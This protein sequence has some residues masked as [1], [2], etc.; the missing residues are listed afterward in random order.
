M[1][2]LFSC[3]AEGSQIIAKTGKSNLEKFIN[4]LLERVERGRKSYEH[5]GNSINYINANGRT[6]L[7]IAEKGTNGRIVFAYLEKIQ[8]EN[9]QDAGTLARHLDSYNSDSNDKVKLIQKEIDSVKD[10][11]MENIEHVLKRGE[12]LEDLMDRTEVIASEASIFKRQATT[13]KNTMWWKNMKLWIA[14]GCVLLLVVLVIIL[15][16]CGISFGNCKP[17]PSPPAPSP[18]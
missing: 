8:K 15:S 5:E 11:M 9:A 12:R 16:V 2:I 6:Y 1:A 10:I 18:A 7:A 14:V 4:K 13:L 17:G 3:V